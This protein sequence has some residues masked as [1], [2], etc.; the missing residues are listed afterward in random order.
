MHAIPIAGLPEIGR[1]MWPSRPKPTR[2]ANRYPLGLIVR[3]RR[4]D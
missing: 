4:V 2:P 1:N 3:P